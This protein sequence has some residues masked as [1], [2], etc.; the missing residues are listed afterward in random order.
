M[1]TLANVAEFVSELKGDVSEP[2]RTLI[3]R[4]LANLL[5]TALQSEPENYKHW[6]SSGCK[7][8]YARCELTCPEK[9]VNDKLDVSETSLAAFCNKWMSV[10]QFKLKDEDT[11]K[12]MTPELNG[13]RVTMVEELLAL[14]KLT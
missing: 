1:I 3:A 10:S 13:L 5:G 12:T 9:W 14:S 11:W 8:F 2:T 4:R 6:V 7:T